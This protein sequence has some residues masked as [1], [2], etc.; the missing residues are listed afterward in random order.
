MSEQLDRTA[1]VRAG[2]ELDPAALRAYL[3]AQ[4]LLAGDDVQVTQYPRGFSNLTYLVSSG[5]A[6]YVLRRPPVGVGKGVAHD[7]V[8]EARILAALGRAYERVPR[9]LATCDDPHVLGAPF[10]LMTRARG[11]ILRDRLPGGLSLDA[12][13]M[14][15]VSTAVID[16]LA[17]IHAVDV[18]AAG[19]SDLGRPQ[20]YVARQVGGWRAR[21]EAARTG[22]QPALESAGE[23]LE[24]NRPEESGVALVHND[25]KFDNLVLDADEPTRVV[26]VL[27]WEMATVGDPLL[28]LG[29]TLAYWVERDDAPEL[30]ALG[31]GITALPGALTRQ[32]LVARYAEV[33]GRPVPHPVFCY[34]FGLFKVAVIAQQIYARYVRGL[35]RDA[36]FATLDG[37]VRALGEAAARAIA[38]GTIGAA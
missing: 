37:A 14:R 18:G 23:W 9:V 1:P 4:G 30:R 16:A 24:A 7:V 13:A 6:E 21:Y 31:L 26:A 5:A 19:L 29:T 3:R 11:L 33:T 8:R 12:A 22:D 36:R 2:E 27:D 20:G 34:A 25:F 10:Y 38:T 15:R 17:G 28:D 32:G 35:T